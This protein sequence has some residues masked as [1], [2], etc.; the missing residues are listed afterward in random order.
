[1]QITMVNQTTQLK[2]NIISLC[3]YFY[4]WQQGSGFTH[5]LMTVFKTFILTLTAPVQLVTIVYVSRFKINN[6]K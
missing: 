1:M 6:Y 5:L 3:M 4:R 2:M